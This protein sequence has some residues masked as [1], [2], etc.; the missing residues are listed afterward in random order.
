M[1][2]GLFIALL[3]IE[4]SLY[5]E[6]T[7]GRVSNSIIH[8]KPLLAMRQNDARS[9]NHRNLNSLKYMILFT[10]EQTGFQLCDGSAEAAATRRMSAEPNCKRNKTS[11]Q[12]RNHQS[13]N[14]LTTTTKSLERIRVRI[15][16]SIASFVCLFHLRSLLSA[17]V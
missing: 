5:I 14:M 17:F 12:L 1:H 10:F 2:R 16:K 3:V 9:H 7:R 8:N 11:L 4:D 15:S 6:L 13:E